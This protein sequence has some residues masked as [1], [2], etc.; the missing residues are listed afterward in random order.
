[1]HPCVNNVNDGCL[2]TAGGIYH[3][4]V[5][6]SLTRLALDNTGRSSTERKSCFPMSLTPS[7]SSRDR[8]KYGGT[9]R[10]SA[11]FFKGCSLGYC[12]AIY[13]Q[14]LHFVCSMNYIP[15]YLFL[16]REDEDDVRDIGK[17]DFRSLLLRPT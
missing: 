7:S 10:R 4:K 8:N 14:E 6:V 2:A 3:N 13:R 1:M 17:F 15:P 9:W 16:S 5:T 11:N 12:D